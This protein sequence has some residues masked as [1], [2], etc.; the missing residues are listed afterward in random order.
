MLFKRE[1]QALT[2]IT[3]IP[4]PCY[5]QGIEEGINDFL[6][7]VFGVTIPAIVLIT[8]FLKVTVTKKTNL[9]PYIV[10]LGLYLGAVCI[11]TLARTIYLYRARSNRASHKDW[12]PDMSDEI[13]MIIT[14]VLGIIVVGVFIF[15]ALKG[16]RAKT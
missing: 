6:F 11:K 15:V 1:I 14:C 3:L 7:V 13:A 10:L 8:L 12:E 16:T 4:I 9:T 2:L 5:A